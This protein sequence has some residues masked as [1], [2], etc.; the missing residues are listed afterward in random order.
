MTGRL[1]AR[2]EEAGRLRQQVAL[3]HRW[4]SPSA[5][6]TQ[7]HP[8]PDHLADPEYLGGEWL[9]Q[10]GAHM[11]AEHMGAEARRRRAPLP[12][13][14]FYFDDGPAEAWEEA[15]G[16]EARRPSRRRAAHRTGSGRR[17]TRRVH[18]RANEWWWTG[19][20]EAAEERRED[21]V[22]TR[23]QELA[24]LR[25]LRKSIQS[26]R[27]AQGLTA[28]EARSHQAMGDGLQQADARDAQDRSGAAAAAAEAAEAP[29]DVDAGEDTAVVEDVEGRGAG[30][31]DGLSQ[32]APGE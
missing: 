31:G 24:A 20:G 19:A 22:E 4:C 2:T 8:D 16:D 9:G 21:D 1:E 18:M 10:A 3:L 32:P 30:G 7:H 6:P 29:A 17:A 15:E 23:L 27:S 12:P 5:W 13:T 26:M 11:G 14:A 28:H 25:A